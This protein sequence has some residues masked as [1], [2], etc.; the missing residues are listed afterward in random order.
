MPLG[1]PSWGLP[2][3]MRLQGAGL[4]MEKLG[5]KQLLQN[6]GIALCQDDWL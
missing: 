1:S 5:L 6:I 4:E 3:Q 2:S